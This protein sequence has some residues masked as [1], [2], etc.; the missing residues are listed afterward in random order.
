MCAY[1]KLNMQTKEIATYRKISIGAVDNRKYRIRKKLNLLPETDLYK[2][3]NS[4]KP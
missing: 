1:L 3:I 2:W 4:I